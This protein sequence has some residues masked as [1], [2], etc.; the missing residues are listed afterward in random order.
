VGLQQTDVALLLLLTHAIAKAA[1]FTSIGGVILNTSTQDMTQMGGLWSKMPVSTMAF[2]AGS[3]GMVALLPLGSFW[4]MERWLSEPAMPSWS[5]AV[6]L[7][8]NGLTALNLARVF[9]LVFG[10]STQPKTRRAPEV[11]WTMAVP[12]VSS[13][14]LTLLVPL[15]LERWQ[16]LLTRV[17]MLQF[18]ITETIALVTSAALGA[19]IGIAI[20]SFGA[21]SRP[22]QLPVP[23]LQ[24][25]L[26]YDFYIDRIYRITI[27]L[28]VGAA[29]RFTAWV[30]RYIIDGLVNL[31]GVAALFGGEG[32]KYSTSGQSQGYVL[33]VLISI[34]MMVVLAGWSLAQLW[35]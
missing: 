32:L 20:Y 15:M 35:F 1:L 25:L 17:G 12:I 11:G 4:A 13:I 24:D 19:A 3:M 27:A 28:V 8:V 14:V 16:L 34:S 26:A 21:V 18:P 33:V 9:G 2:V 6:V 30:D 31:V 7:L 10:G 29:A 22:V 23:A 5:I